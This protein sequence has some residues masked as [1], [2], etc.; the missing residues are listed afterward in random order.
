MSKVFTSANNDIISFG[1]PSALQNVGGSPGSKTIMAW[2]YPTG[3]GGASYGRIWDKG[4]FQTNGW[5][6]Y[7]VDGDN[8]SEASATFRM[9]LGGTTQAQA[10]AVHDT[11]SLNKWW[12]V[13]GT[14]KPSD[15]GPRLWVGSLSAAMAEVSSYSGFG[16]RQDVTSYGSDAGLTAY[17]GNRAAVDRGFDGR[18]EHLAVWDNALSSDQME[19]VRIVTYPP[20]WRFSVAGTAV[21]VAGYWPF[22]ESTASV[23]R[24]HTS[25]LNHGT[26]TGT[27]VGA[28]AAVMVRRGVMA[29]A[30]A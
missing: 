14:Y 9:V 22:F 7:V 18:I 5:F 25:N 4:T 28:S 2:I 16:P 12:C 24:D 6:F 11:L 17:S 13:G 3:W 20:R 26:V 10:T 8:V 27:T 21:A 30:A 19:A 23:A 15:G 29:Q 1:T